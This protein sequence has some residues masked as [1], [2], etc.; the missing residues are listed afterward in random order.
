MFPNYPSKQQTISFLENKIDLC[1][2]ISDAMGFKGAKG[3]AGYLHRELN[4]ED[5]KVEMPRSSYL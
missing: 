4:T 2:R 1:K 3:Q 5:I